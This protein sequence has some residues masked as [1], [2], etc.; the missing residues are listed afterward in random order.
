MRYPVASGVHNSALVALQTGWYREPETRRP[1]EEIP[2]RAL[3]TLGLLGCL[4]ASLLRTTTGGADSLFK[5]IGVVV[6]LVGTN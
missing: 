4:A 6:A 2:M 1:G 5:R 3:A